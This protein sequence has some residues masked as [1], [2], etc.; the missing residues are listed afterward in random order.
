MCYYS[1]N[2]LS[3]IC[4]VCLFYIYIYMLKT[5]VIRFKEDYTFFLN[6]SFFIN[7]I[8]FFK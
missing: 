3:Q 4:S 1:A 5:C 6:I 2:N 7:F 8:T